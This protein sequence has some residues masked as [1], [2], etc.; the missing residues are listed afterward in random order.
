MTFS[1]TMELLHHG[2]SLQHR[3]DDIRVWIQLLVLGCWPK[4]LYQHSGSFCDF[5]SLNIGWNMD[6]E[7]D[8]GISIQST[9]IP[10]TGVHFEAAEVLLIKQGARGL[11]YG[12]IVQNF[13]WEENLYGNIKEVHGPDVKMKLMG[14]QHIDNAQIKVA[15]HCHVEMQRKIHV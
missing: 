7:C 12:L 2:L 8:F 15:Q 6:S 3:T 5:V 4:C 10:S 1:L 11:S 14:A 13:S 9:M